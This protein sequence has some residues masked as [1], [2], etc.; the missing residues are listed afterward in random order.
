VACM[1]SVEKWVRGGKEG[2]L[3]GTYQPFTTD[4]PC[5][6]PVTS[7]APGRRTWRWRGG[8]GWAQDHRPGSEGLAFASGGT[9]P[10]EEHWRSGWAGRVWF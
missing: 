9:L 2:L 8:C 6:V 1:G 7:P 3:P 4:S 5:E 10:Q